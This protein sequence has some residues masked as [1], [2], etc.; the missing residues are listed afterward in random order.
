MTNAS[1]ASASAAT[2]GLDEQLKALQDDLNNA[3]DRYYWFHYV[4]RRI[5]SVGGV[6][7]LFYGLLLFLLRYWPTDE[8]RNGKK[9]LADFFGQDVIDLFLRAELHVSCVILILVI[10]LGWKLDGVLGRL[11]CS[12]IVG[13]V[14][15]LVAKYQGPDNSVLLI[16][17]MHG[18][19]LL[20]IGLFLNRTF[21]YTR[22][23][24]RAEFYLE[25]VTPLLSDAVLSAEKKQE[26][27]DKIM[28]ARRTDKYR[29][30][31]G[32]TFFVLDGLKE[33]LAG[34]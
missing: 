4:A 26:A 14:A 28:E 6:L 9:N 11:I 1:G 3:R 5:T 25:M 15:A 34:G 17:A 31:V 2:G 24:A 7:A 30:L 33:K 32:D 21:G 22:S 20:F 19:L 18:G 16:R 13:A 23:W 29:D 12:A 8:Q 10:C 27:Y